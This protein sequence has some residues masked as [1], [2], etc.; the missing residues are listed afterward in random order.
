MLEN[1]GG[2]YPADSV[3]CLRRVRYCTSGFA[4]SS[5]QRLGIGT[6]GSGFVPTVAGCSR[7][8]LLVRGDVLQVRVPCFAS[9]RHALSICSGLGSPGSL[10]DLDFAGD[11]PFVCLTVSGSERLSVGDLGRPSGSV[12]A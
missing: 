12:L 6:Q 1:G 7:G 10:N 9:A 2:K 8:T 4:C 3:S 5:R 11:T